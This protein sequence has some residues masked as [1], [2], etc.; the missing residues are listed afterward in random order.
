[1]FLAIV[2]IRARTEFTRRLLM[3]GAL[4][5]PVKRILCADT[6]AI[7]FIVLFGV[8][9]SQPLPEPTAELALIAAIAPQMAW[10]HPPPNSKSRIVF[11]DDPFPP[12]NYD[13]LYLLGL[14]YRIRDPFVHRMKSMS[15]SNSPDIHSYDYIFTFE[16]RRLI[17]LKP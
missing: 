12:E 9:R 10:I 16:G 1:L 14:E 2:V 13:P 5:G 4:T 17:Q 3:R 11:L 7:C 6:F 8:H 15:A